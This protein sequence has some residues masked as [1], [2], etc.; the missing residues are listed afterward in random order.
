MPAVALDRG[1]PLV[2]N[3][4][5]YKVD[6]I[7]ED[8]EKQIVLRSKS[9]GKVKLISQLE[10]LRKIKEGTIQLLAARDKDAERTRRL[11]EKLGQQL[12]Q[13]GDKARAAFERRHRYVKEFLKH[14]PVSKTQE[15]LIPIIEEIAAK[16]ND[17]KPPHWT[18]LCG[19]VRDYQAAQNDPRGLIPSYDKRGGQKRLCSKV[20][21]LIEDAIDDVYLSRLQGTAEQVYD[22]VKTRIEDFNFGLKERERL[23][24]PSKRTIYRAL[25]KLD[26]YDKVHKRSG[27]LAADRL[28]GAFQKG[29]AVTRPLERVEIDHT[30]L[31]LLLI[32][33]DTF[34][35]IG[36]PILTIAIDCYTRYIFGFYIGFET[37][38][39]QSVMHC[40]RHGIWHKEELRE[41]YP[42]IQNEWQC[43]GVPETIVVDNGKEFHSK[44][45]VRACEQLNIQI[46]YTPRKK[47]WFKPIVEHIFHT[48]DMQML[49][50]APG[51]TVQELYDCVE[52]YPARDAAIGL[53]QFLEAFHVWVVDVYHQKFHEGLGERPAEAWQ[54]AADAYDGI[55][56]PTNRVDLWVTL[57]SI[58]ERTLTKSGVRLHGL[59]YNNE[60]L[61]HVR[62]KLA[63][64]RNPKLEVKYDP[65]N[66]E[67]IYVMLPGGDYLAVPA[68]DKDYTYNL[69]MFQHQVVLKWRKRQR[70]EDERSM[71]LTRARNKI[72]DILLRARAHQLPVHRQRQRA[73]L[74]G[75]GSNNHTSRVTTDYPVSE[76]YG[77]IIE[78]HVTN[79]TDN[80]KKDEAPRPHESE[81]IIKDHQSEEEDYGWSLG[82]NSY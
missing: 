41:K 26:N 54:K 63:T 33:E 74:D 29:P 10:I 27:R 46:L 79:I 59:F 68:I 36:R 42:A 45:F 11:N 13:L 81:Q 19:W 17:T 72:R 52:F 38:G 78:G 23:S 37:A 44:A 51:H 50:G 16:I 22:Q 66:L 8:N 64:N 25:E 40:L 57:S 60:E 75:E 55:K 71:S 61:A 15:R 35:V 34:M 48:M 32:D 39:W 82:T 28:F 76:E 70:T 47:P 1:L 80:Q 56:L 3:G 20:H 12:D 67:E 30:P 4:A 53:N 77:R 6:G 69:N 31:N 62:S 73:R 9:S 18:T 2:M 21:D 7:Q 14:R 5:R 65:S 49:R 24:V 43:Y 58:E